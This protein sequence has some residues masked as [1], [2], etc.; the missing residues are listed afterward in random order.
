MGREASRFTSRR[1]AMKIKALITMLVLGASSAAMASPAEPTYQAQPDPIV[2]D[3][4]MPPVAQAESRDWWSWNR[5]RTSYRR[6]HTV[7]LGTGLSFGQGRK[8]IT[9]GPQ[10]GRFDMVRIEGS[11]GRTLVE[12]VYIE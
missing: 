1:N 7:D 5:D 8:F 9:V 4:R 6:S 10:M 11:T 3:H 2:R 12:Q